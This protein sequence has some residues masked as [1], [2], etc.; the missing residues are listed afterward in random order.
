M[1]KSSPLVYRAGN[2]LALLNPLILLNNKT[3]RDDRN[4]RPWPQGGSSCPGI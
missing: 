4:T 2:F 1:T 3:I